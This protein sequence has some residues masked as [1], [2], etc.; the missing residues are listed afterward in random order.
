MSADSSGG[1][2]GLLRCGCG[3]DRLLLNDDLPSV[4]FSALTWGDEAC[5]FDAF[6]LSYAAIVDGDLN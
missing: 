2:V 3:L 5:F 6:D 1:P 4:D